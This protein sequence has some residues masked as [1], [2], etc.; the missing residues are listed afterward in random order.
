MKQLILRLPL[1][2]PEAARIAKT[3][4]K[5]LDG[6][7]ETWGLALSIFQ[8]ILYLAGSPVLLVAIYGLD[9]LDREATES[10]L[11]SLLTE[12]KDAMSGD[13]IVG[14]Q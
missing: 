4:S 14:C 12:L 5:A 10:T 2:I 9:M 11:T 3:R 1:K 13:D 7:L 6:T 8:E